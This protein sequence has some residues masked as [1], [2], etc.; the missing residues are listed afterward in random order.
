MLH[1]AERAHADDVQLLPFGC[2]H[3]ICYV[4]DPRKEVSPPK[5]IKLMQ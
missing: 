4:Y 5:N 2:R 1:E 3:V